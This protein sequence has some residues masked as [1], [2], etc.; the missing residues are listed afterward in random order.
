MCIRL[1]SCCCF[2][3]FCCFFLLVVCLLVCV[4]FSL[5]VLK[6]QLSEQ[7]EHAN[8]GKRTSL[9]LTEDTANNSLRGTWV[10]HKTPMRQ[11]R[12]STKD[13]PKLHLFFFSNKRCR[14]WT[15][16]RHSCQHLDSVWKLVPTASCVVTIG[17]LTVELHIMPHVLTLI[18]TGYKV[19]ICHT[20][21]DVLCPSMIVY[22]KDEHLIRISLCDY[23]RLLSLL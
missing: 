22:P 6:L 8:Q 3:V 7:K 2:F 10:P 21:H 1:C 12:V 16:A 20:G 13:Y 23:N 19:T 18:G 11:K 9:R 15:C 5:S 14:R 17:M 4:F